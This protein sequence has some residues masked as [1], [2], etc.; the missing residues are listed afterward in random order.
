MATFNKLKSTTIYGNFNNLDYPDNSIQA[1]ANFQRNL[2][3][4]GNLNLGTETSTTDPNTHITTYTD[5]GGNITFKINNVTYTITPTILSYL[6]N[7]NSDLSTKFNNYAL[8][9]SLSSYAPLLNPIFTGNPKAITQAITDASTNIA[10]TQ[11]VQNITSPIYN[12]F[13]PLISTTTGGG[14]ASLTSGLVMY[15][16]FDNSTMTLFL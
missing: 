15:F 1:S 5:T 6:I 11:I 8:I 9:S 13:L 2:N 16:P 7:I 4:G 3:I 14:L 12:I 10:T